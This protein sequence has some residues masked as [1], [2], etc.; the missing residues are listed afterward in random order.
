MYHSVTFGDKNTWDDWHLIPTSRPLFAPPE[1]RSRYVEIPGTDGNLN[2][3]EIL[4]GY[5]VFN[6]REG[7]MEFAV[8][9]D[10]WDWTVAYSTI[11]NYLHGKALKAIL[12]D[13]PGFYYEGRF[14]VD[15]WKSDKY[16]STITINYNVYPFKMDLLSTMD[17]W[18]W[19]TFNFETGIIQETKD[20]LVNGTR[21]AIIYASGV[22]SLPEITADSE[23][24]VKFRDRNYTLPAGKT[25][26]LPQHYLEGEN[27]FV[28][29]G[30]G[31]VS[32]NYRGGML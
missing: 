3:S 15:E 27:T 6:N 24:T 22:R 29:T 2:L 18:I 5:P 4:T 1:P 10:Y 14:W 8:A 26:R 20:M 13:D 16:Y 11:M 32:I 21:T 9:N 7:S 30:N 19:D 25:I 23:M 31:K 17:P 12:E 28:F